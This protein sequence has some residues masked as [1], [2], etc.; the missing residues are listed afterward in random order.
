MQRKN[1]PEDI[2]QWWDNLSEKMKWQVF[3]SAWCWSLLRKGETIQS[4]METVGYTQSAINK[5][6]SKVD[7]TLRLAEHKK[8]TKPTFWQSNYD[9]DPKKLDRK[10]KKYW[11]DDESMFNLPGL[12]FYLGCDKRT[13]FDSLTDGRLPEEIIN[14]LKSAKVKLEAMQ[15]NSIQYSPAGGIFNL[16]NNHDYTDKVEIKNETVESDVPL[17]DKLIAHSNKILKESSLI[18]KDST[19]AEVISV[20]DLPS[21]D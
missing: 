9:N 7:I 6:L 8:Y 1:A 19:D 15:L 12:C 10:L 4:S 21:E 3:D 2:N 14:I 18:Q 5:V 13:F 20:D 11:K 16:K 17:D